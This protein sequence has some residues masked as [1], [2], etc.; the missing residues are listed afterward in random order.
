[1]F[2]VEFQDKVHGEFIEFFNTFDEAVEYWQAY[3]DTPT[4]VN[5]RLCDEEAGEIIWEF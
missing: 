1:M 2:V 4:C 5:G 3:A